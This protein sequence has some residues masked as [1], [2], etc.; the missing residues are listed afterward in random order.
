MA[1]DSSL[2]DCFLADVY[3]EVVIDRDQREKLYPLIDSL[4]KQKRFNRIVSESDLTWTRPS[5]VFPNKL[6]HNVLYVLAE[7]HS[8]R[9]LVSAELTRIFNLTMTSV[10]V[11]NRI[12]ADRRKLK[13]VRVRVKPEQIYR[14]AFF[15]AHLDESCKVSWKSDEVPI[16]TKLETSP[17]KIREF[18]VSV[19]EFVKQD[20]NFRSFNRQDMLK[21]LRE[22][23]IQEVIKF[24]ADPQFTFF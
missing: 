24:R 17:S 12:K 18:I 4:E 20:E 15:T 9:S 22:V 1:L 14:K 6:S 2:L 8:N 10:Q 3:P 5:K 7:M 19:I 21:K 13:S 11:R 23:D 16:K